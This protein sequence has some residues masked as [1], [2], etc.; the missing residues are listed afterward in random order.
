MPSGLYAAQGGVQRAVW[1][2]F[3]ESGRALEAY[4]WE[5]I[6]KVSAA[7]LASQYWMVGDTKTVTLD[8]YIYHMQIIGFD[9]DDIDSTDAMYGTGYNGGV[10]K[11]GITFG[12]EGLLSTIHPKVKTSSTGISLSGSTWSV[13]S[14]RMEI[15]PTY[16][17]QM[18]ES[19]KASLR[20]VK[21]VT[22][23]G[24]PDPYRTR[25]TTADTL[26]LLSVLNISS[27]YTNIVGDAD[28]EYA[29]YAE[30]GSTRKY[31]PGDTVSSDWWTRSRNLSESDMDYMI[32]YNG[33]VTQRPLTLD[34]GVSFAFCV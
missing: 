7:G 32:T 1:P 31:K 21:K 17:N 15:L 6:A 19:L 27:G 25:E 18:P 14:M 24:A 4:T 22:A 33:G 16:Q 34:H 29:Y 23:I 9:H 13:C 5:E 26:F 3:P 8:G 28:S 2:G 20:T 10:G 11:A 30:G 12:M